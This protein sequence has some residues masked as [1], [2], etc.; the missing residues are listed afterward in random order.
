MWPAMKVVAKLRE[1]I[2]S[3]TFGGDMC[4]LLH[5]PPIPTVPSLV[6]SA[7]F[8]VSPSQPA[9]N[10]YPVYGHTLSYSQHGM[11]HVHY[12]TSTINP[13]TLERQYAYVDQL[14]RDDE[15]SDSTHPEPEFQI[16]YNYVSVL[17][18]IPELTVQDTRDASVT[19]FIPLT[20]AFES[21]E[22][23]PSYRAY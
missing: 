9:G 8:F 10:G 23:Y 13:A 1:L 18:G 15:D 19:G 5:P 3:G 2:E 20:Y 4:A 6:Q 14:H 17:G 12:D 21:R 16:P 22:A 7:D 11:P